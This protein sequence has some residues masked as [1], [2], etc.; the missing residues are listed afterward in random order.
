MKNVGIQPDIFHMN[1]GEGSI[2]DA[3]RAAGDYVKHFHMNET[4]HREHGTGHADYSAILQA[5]KD[6]KYNGY[7]A[8]YMPYTTQAIFNMAAQGYGQS[9]GDDGESKRS[10]LK[11]YLEKPLKL[12]KELEA[13]G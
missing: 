10:D 3:I 6:I 5:L 2:P 11:A 8:F 7:I 4:N 12:F 13:N 9:S 1:V